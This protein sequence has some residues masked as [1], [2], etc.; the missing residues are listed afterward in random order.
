[1]LH[2]KTI[3]CFVWSTKETS[4]CTY[5]KCRVICIWIWGIK[6]TGPEGLDVQACGHR[7]VLN[8]RAWIDQEC[9]R[10]K[11]T[12]HIR[13]TFFWM[14]QQCAMKIMIGDSKYGVDMILPKMELKVSNLWHFILF[15][16]CLSHTLSF[17]R[18]FHLIRLETKARKYYD[19]IISWKELAFFVYNHMRGD[20]T[21]C[22]LWHLCVHHPIWG[23][24]VI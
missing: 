18:S 19:N 20:S 3:Y 12:P 7:V 17:C 10:R 16:H 21:Y 14:Q 2:F 8:S 13:F 23:S 11:S 22:D 1:M 24:I 5:R 4:L 15:I 9:R 6:Y